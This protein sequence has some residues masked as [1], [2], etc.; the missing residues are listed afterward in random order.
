MP[1]K[2]QTISVSEVIVILVPLFFRL[3]EILSFKL[4]FLSEDL[5]E[6]MSR[7]ASSTP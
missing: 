5:I 7:N 4:R 3:F 2:K 6:A 1:V